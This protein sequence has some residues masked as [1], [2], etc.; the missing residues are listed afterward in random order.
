MESSLK[1][2]QNSFIMLTWSCVEELI[3]DEEGS[4]FVG[5]TQYKPTTNNISIK[6][7]V[8]LQPPPRNWYKLNFDGAFN[9][10]CLHGGVSGIIRNNKG[11][12]ILGYYEKY[13]TT[14]PIQA[15]LLAL[16]HALQIISKKNIFPCE[17]ETD[18]RNVIRFL[19]EDYP[20]Y[21]DLIHECRWLMEKALQ[22]GEII[23][24]HNFREGNMVARQLAKEALMCPSYNKTLYVVS[25]PTFAIDAYCKD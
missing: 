7:K 15:E 19:D 17:V 5:Y 8:K 22:Q 1:S 12:W 25:P 9:K 24:K 14:S 4:G 10:S 11:E 6:L 18:A 2:L 3:F 23:M 16:R 13:Q 21:N 20:T